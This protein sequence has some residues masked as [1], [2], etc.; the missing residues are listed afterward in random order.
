VVIVICLLISTLSQKLPPKIP[1]VAVTVV[2]VPAAG[3]VPPIVTPF[4][5]PPVIVTE[6]AF[7]VAIVPNPL[8]SPLEI[9]PHAGA[10]EAAP[11]PVWV[12]KFLVVV[13]LPASFDSVL[14]ADA[15]NVSPVA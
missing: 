6:L 5:V 10:A 8:I 15:Y 2:N 7:W 13:V 1:N 11:V 3:V 4:I 12:K 9:V 14:V